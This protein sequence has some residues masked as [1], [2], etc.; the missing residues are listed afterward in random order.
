M[1]VN[2]ERMTMIT[3]GLGCALVGAAGAC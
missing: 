3:Y 2:V 1:G